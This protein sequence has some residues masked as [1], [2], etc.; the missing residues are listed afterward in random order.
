MLR[1]APSFDDT[2]PPVKPN[3]DYDPPAAHRKEM[4]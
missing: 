4:T 2:F 3:E 1:S